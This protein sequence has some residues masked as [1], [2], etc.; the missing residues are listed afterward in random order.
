MSMWSTVLMA[1]GEAKKKKE[2]G[3]CA[4]GGAVYFSLAIPR[5][6]NRERER[7]REKVLWPV[8]AIKAG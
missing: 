4:T 6:Y 7:E 2:E 8:K 1:K 5:R 3:A